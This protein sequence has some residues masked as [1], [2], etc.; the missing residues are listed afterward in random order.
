MDPTSRKVMAPRPLVRGARPTKLSRGSAGQRKSCHRPMRPVSGMCKKPPAEAS[1]IAID[2][3][4]MEFHVGQLARRSR[5]A[6][7]VVGQARADIRMSLVLSLR[8]PSRH[9]DPERFGSRFANAPVSVRNPLHGPTQNA[10]GE[11]RSPAVGRLRRWR[12]AA[13][14]GRGVVRVGGVRLRPA[15]GV[16]PA[17]PG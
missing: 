13:V 2:A 11:S 5:W 10:Q 16:A 4:R 1:A 6:I 3:C 12:P 17:P 15:G 7:A 8:A 9:E 14:P